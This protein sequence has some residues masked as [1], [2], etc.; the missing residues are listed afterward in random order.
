MVNRITKELKTNGNPAGIG[1]GV[2][3][4]V[5]VILATAM[6][7][8]SVFEALGGYLTDDL[9]IANPYH[10]QIALFINYWLTEYNALPSEGDW[11]TWAEAHHGME[12]MGIRS[13]MADLRKQNISAYTPK[14]I[15]EMAGPALK[16][17][18]VI[19]AVARLN[20][21]GYR[22][23]A[24]TWDE[25]A[26]RVESLG[27]GAK[28]D[29]ILASE[30]HIKSTDWVWEPYIPAGT[31]TL[32][33]GDPEIGKSQLCAW[34]A[35]MITRLG[36]F[37]W[38]RGRV[39]IASAE[40]DVARTIG[41]RLVAAG[42]D[43]SKVRV[44]GEAF[45]LTNADHVARLRNEVASFK[46]LLTIID[47]ISCYA[48]RAD[49]HRDTEVRQMLGTL[50]EISET[51]D[52]T[53][54]AVRHPTK[55][56]SGKGIYRGMGSIAFIAA[57]RS[58]IHLLALEDDDGNPTGVYALVHLKSNLGKKGM[59]RP[60]RI[61]TV[62]IEDYD[63]LEM[64]SSRLAFLDREEAMEIAT[65]TD[66]E[67]AGRGRRKTMQNRAVDWVEELM[68]LHNGLIP[69]RAGEDLAEAAGFGKT[70]IKRARKAVGILSEQLK[71]ADLIGRG[72]DADTAA[73]PGWWWHLPAKEE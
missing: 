69:A 58:T 43:L 11:A 73:Q 2:A 41:P 9:V 15:I 22:P 33:E 5:D 8:R 26:R 1:K 16:D 38:K 45:D 18:A 62:E 31:L 65:V 40:D 63:G 47:P 39:L 37:G 52:T 51:C 13:A 32:I 46:P 3:P 10:L 25:M 67:I 14:Y 19:N 21:E 54:A 29:T 59:Q 64:N 24:E 48:G 34:L 7:E 28:L 12:T 17:V 50:R 27:Q 61:E 70:T 49:A 57:A 53:F 66:D 71:A 42:A 72:I 68:E 44:T 60:Y 6:Q 35:A 4:S 55:D 56:T 20:Q 36:R 23:S 30:I